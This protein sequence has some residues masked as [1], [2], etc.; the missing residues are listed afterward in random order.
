MSNDRPRSAAQVPDTALPAHTGSEEPLILFVQHTPAAVALLDLSFRYIITS[1]RWRRDFALDELDLKQVS[2]F[3]VFR[4]E[5]GQWRSTFQ[6][7]L[8]GTVEQGQETPFMAATGRLFWVDWELR[9]WYQTDGNVGGL[10]IF[11]ENR[12]EQKQ[13]E[14]ELQISRDLLSSILTSSLDGV[15]AFRAVR[16]DDDQVVDFE[17]LMANPRS[18]Q[19]TGR[20]AGRLVGQRLL[21]ELPGNQESGLF[22]AYVEVVRTGTPFETEMRYDHD[23]IALWLRIAAVPLGDGFSV[24]FRDITER[25]EAEQLL[26]RTNAALRQRNRELQDFA[27]VASHDLQEP[28]R[29]V[30]AFSNLLVE[31]YSEALDETAQYYLNRV[32]D[33]AQRMSQLISDLLAFSRV[34]TK[35]QPFKAVDLGQV[36][37]EILADLEMMVQEHGARVELGPLPTIEADHT[38][39]RQLFQNL[40]SNALKFHQADVQPAITV[41]ATPRPPAEEGGVDQFEITVQDNG[42]GFD[43]KYLDRIFSPFQ[44]LHG[45]NAYPGTGMGLAI[46][47]RIIERH[48]GH[49]TARS[50]PGEG[51]TFIVTLPAQ[52]RTSD[53]SAG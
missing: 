13:A 23:G 30:R 12:T 3:E 53:P 10:I 52:Q 9:P 33:S 28:L 17:C 50:S 51:T 45:R 31:D 22:E 16:D 5:P 32:E 1:S 29:K 11:A 39:M 44:R 38:Q 19:L 27:Y 46:C 42:I 37:N 43:E 15:M 24:T 2:H 6:H 47:R 7:G 26:D 18:V 49:L 35:A 8:A 21:A 41:H 40:I 34:L 48:H 4:D 14:E 20:P 25:K 36:L